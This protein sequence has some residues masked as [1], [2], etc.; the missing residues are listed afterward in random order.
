MHFTWKNKRKKENLKEE[1]RSRIENTMCQ[2]SFLTPA[3]T[4]RSKY[5]IFM[6]KKNQHKSGKPAYISMKSSF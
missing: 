3:C 2:L 5:I 1:A 6:G 4:F